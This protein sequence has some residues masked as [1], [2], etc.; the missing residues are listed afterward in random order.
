[1]TLILLFWGAASLA[2]FILY[3]ADKHKAR[4]GTWR[5]SEK[6]LLTFSVLGGAAGGL[7]AM[8]FFH[9]KTKHRYFYVVNIG[10]LTVHLVAIIYFVFFA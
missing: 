8:Q 5:I 7:A 2:T 9:H 3:A 6:T 10:A 4:H 1:M